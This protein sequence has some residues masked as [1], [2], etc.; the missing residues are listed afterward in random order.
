[1]RNLSLTSRAHRFR[2]TSPCLVILVGLL[3]PV[4]C[5]GPT[6]EE[7]TPEPVAEKPALAEEAPIPPKVVIE[8]PELPEGEA[9]D[10]GFTISQVML[11]AHD[12]KLY[13]EILGD[14]PD[15][16]TVGVMQELYADLPKR[17]PPKGEIE[18]WE[19]RATALVSAVD[20][21]AA[22]DPKGA[23]QL[24]RA[25]NCSSCHSRHR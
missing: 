25:V 15:P 1:M 24:K 2:V 6:S 19:E 5:S 8:L 18:D 12:S 21:I 9:E 3:S 16:E 7:T 10:G 11:A 22:G 4:G 14:S 13:R 17:T 20:A 23:N